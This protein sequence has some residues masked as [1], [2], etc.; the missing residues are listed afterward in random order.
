MRL[1]A[2]TSVQF[3]EDTVQN[4]IA[5]KLKLAFFDYFRFHPSPA[6]VNSWKNSLRALSQVFQYAELRDQGIILEYQLPLSSKRLD[7]L[8]C[9]KDK[10]NKDNAVIIELKQWDKCEEAAGE[11]EVLTFV[12]GA[13]REVLHPSVQ[14]GQYK[15]YLEDTH[16]AFNESDDHVVLHACTYLHNYN[17]Y[18]EDVI[19]ASKYK[20]ALDNFPL[21]SADDVTK[22]KEYLVCKLE[23]GNG[24]EILKKIEE[25]RYKPSKK[26]MDHVG[27]IIKGK[28]EY[29]LL[30]E[31]LI[32]YDKVFSSAK[33][34]FHDKQKHVIIIKGGPGTGKSVIALNLM[35]DLLLKGYNAHYATGSK[36]S[37]IL[38]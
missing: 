29:V 37:T 7:C 1:Y 32:V 13:K 17:Y 31:Q 6:E 18:S 10:F 38:A 19:Y 2:G 22:F 5:E 35:A 25:S 20:I 28:S 26:L 30:D 3:I 16:T 24:R 27:N 33:E 8:I 34:G 23:N 15:M 14:V 9:G 4:Q 11:N 12:G 21:F 36:G